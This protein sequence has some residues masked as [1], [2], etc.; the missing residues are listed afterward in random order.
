MD[1]NEKFYIVWMSIASISVLYNGWV[2]PLRSTFPY[3][4][5]QNRAIWMMFDY[6][7][8]TIYLA[9]MI[10]IQSRIQ[11]LQDGFWVTDRTLLRNRYMKSI[12]FKLDLVSLFPLDLLYF[13]ISPEIVLVRF[14]RFFKIHTF[15]EFCSF[16]DKLLPSPYI[17]R[18]IKTLMY[19]MFLI[20]LNACAYYA[21]SSWEGIGR[22]AFVYSGKG[23]AYIKCFYFA[24]KTAT[25]IG[26]NPKPTQ[27]WEYIFMTFSW[28]MGVFV[29]ALLI[30][31]IRDIISTATRSRTDFKKLVDETLQCMRRLSLPQDVQKRVKLW[32]NYTWETQR[33]LDENK[34]LECLP[35]KMKTDIAINVHIRTLNKVKLFADC[36]EAILRELVLK[37]KSVYIC[38]EISY[39]RKEM[40]AR[41]CT[42]FNLEKLRYVVL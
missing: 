37:L 17:I 32:F 19:M 16:V 5:P 29:F 9:D 40:L 12:R 3:Q 1:P 34:I 24:T 41:R 23:N 8:D 11:Y 6:V 22:N 42:L 2:I 18:L 4:T 35:H 21:F 27:E 26:K 14:P 10:F 39:V 36:D 7:A 38:L 28:L 31:Q 20:H 15:T 25:S 33:A 13:V 30:G